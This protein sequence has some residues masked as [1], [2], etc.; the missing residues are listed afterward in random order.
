[1]MPTKPVHLSCYRG[2][3]VVQA[4]PE[5]A[6]FARVKMRRVCREKATKRGRVRHVGATIGFIVLAGMVIWVS[7]DLNQSLKGLI[8]VSQQ[9]LEQL[10][11]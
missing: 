4:V 3:T 9:P 11:S 7:L 6:N 8:R 5:I 2:D 10:L 1:M